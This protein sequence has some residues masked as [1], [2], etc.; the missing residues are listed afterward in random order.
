ME[1]LWLIR[2][3]HRPIYSIAK[4]N[5]IE[6]YDRRCRLES[7]TPKPKAR[8]D[9]EIVDIIGEGAVCRESL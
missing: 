6:D 1:R 8:V 4:K 2:H 5:R 7:L 9:A 3:G